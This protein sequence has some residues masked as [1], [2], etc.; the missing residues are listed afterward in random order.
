MGSININ[1]AMKMYG[2]DAKNNNT[3]NLF[4]AMNNN[5]KESSSSIMDILG[6]GGSADA[7]GFD[8]GN[9]SAIKNG[10]Y[11]K[12]MK[13]YYSSEGQGEVSKKELETFTKKL[14]VT[15]DKA[16]SVTSAVD[17]LIDADYSEEKREA[18]K[19]KVTAFVD[20][21]NSMVKNVSDSDSK[22]ILQK[23]AWMTGMVKQYAD[24]LGNVGITVDSNN[25]LEI[26]EEAL[27]KADMTSLKS[28]F[29]MDPQ[30]FSNK[31]LYKAEQIY[32]LAK[33]YGNSATAYTSNGTYNR[34]YTGVSNYETTT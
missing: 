22:D 3:R 29:G 8:Y 16:A 28:I 24:E 26:D 21:Y 23:G 7:L 1:D 20:A 9:L 19:D 30:S 13:N 31:V 25:K 27:D 12:L 18:V 10:S 11:Y 17:E 15:A 5:K 33:T 6:G 14:D 4:D 32:S 2:Y 34:N